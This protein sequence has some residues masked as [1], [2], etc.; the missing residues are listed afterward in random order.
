MNIIKLVDVA[1]DVCCKI[2]LTE[3]CPGGTLLAAMERYNKSPSLAWGSRIVSYFRQIVSAVSYMHSHH[4]VHLDLKQEN[5]VLSADSKVVKVIDFGFSARVSKV[6]QREMKSLQGSPWYM[7][8][9][10]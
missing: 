6:Y 3:Y 10:V 2:I 9:E 7:A 1:T 5:V 4:F 8:P